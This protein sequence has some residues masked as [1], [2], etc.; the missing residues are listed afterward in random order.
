MI[1]TDMSSIGTTPPIL[2]RTI[3][4]RTDTGV[5]RVQN[6]KYILT[7]QIVDGTAINK[8]HAKAIIITMS[9]V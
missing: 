1:S 2:L 6:N 7:V 5:N 8:L 3:E 4:K 9:F